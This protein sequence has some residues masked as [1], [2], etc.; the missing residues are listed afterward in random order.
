MPVVPLGKT[1]ARIST[2]KEDSREPEWPGIDAEARTSG[3]S[4]K[5][6]TFDEAAG[7]EEGSPMDGKGCVYANQHQDT[8]HIVEWSCS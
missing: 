7:T 5:L 1:V 2:K 4:G 8:V 3:R 6:A